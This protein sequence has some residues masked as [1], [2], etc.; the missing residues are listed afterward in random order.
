M[1]FACGE[2]EPKLLVSIR[3]SNGFS[4]PLPAAALLRTGSISSL[5][6]RMSVAAWV[7]AIVSPSTISIQPVFF[8]FGPEL[9][10]HRFG[11]MAPLHHW[12]RQKP[13]LLPDVY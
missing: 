13:L 7:P 8:R 3:S 11:A 5:L 10:L 1:I 9:P 2:F 12:C 4:L 6:K